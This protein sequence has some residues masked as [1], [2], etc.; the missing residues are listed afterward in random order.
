[1]RSAPPQLPQD[2]PREARNGQAGGDPAPAQLVVEMIR[3]AQAR[4]RHAHPLA[5]TII[6]FFRPRR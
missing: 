3:A 1:M 2:E 5:S 4:N 6:F